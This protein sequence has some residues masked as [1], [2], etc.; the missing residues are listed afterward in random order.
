[1]REKDVY[2]GMKALQLEHHI[3]GVRFLDFH[4]D[5]EL[6]SAAETKKGG[7]LCYL[8]RQGMDGNHFKAYGYQVTCDYA[9]YALGLSK[10][11]STIVEGRSF[12]FCGLNATKA[13]G[14]SIGTAMKYIPQTL[15]G[16]EIGPLELMEDADIVII[17][18]YA[19]QIM[20]V[21]QSYVYHYG[22]AKNLSCY[23]NQA[24]CS[25]MVSKVFTNQDI[26]ISLMCKGTRQYGRF[27]RGEMLAGFPISMFDKMI[28]GMVMTINP[29]EYRPAK[30][31]ILNSLAYPEELGIEIDMTY[32]YG[33]GLRQYDGMVQQRREK[34][35][36][37]H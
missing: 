12:N 27:D 20:R 18:G 11:D 33:M 9:R 7:P 24:M 26:N 32:N 4:E 8:V 10:P 17:A 28:D 23:G 22:E 25:D 13:S 37:E 19:E 15:Y 16:I 31:K 14:K 21:M 6:C 36:K 3:V 5:Y 35:E 34:G 2:R 29:V 1:M 30:E